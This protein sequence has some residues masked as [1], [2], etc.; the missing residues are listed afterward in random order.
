MTQTNLTPH[1]ITATVSLVRE[2]NT[3]R[4]GW[5]TAAWL[6]ALSGHVEAIGYAMDLDDP[7]RRRVMSI[8]AGLLG[9]SEARA[10]YPA[11]VSRSI[12]IER[13]R[14]L[15]DATAASDAIITLLPTLTYD[16]TRA[17]EYRAARVLRHDA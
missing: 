9:G 12:D 7:M 2:A 11:G 14:Q 5:P 4:D 8:A 1:R 3:D 6:R 10:V 15:D 17:E 13:R 16:A